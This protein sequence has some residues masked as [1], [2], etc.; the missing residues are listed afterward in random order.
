MRLVL[1]P[2]AQRRLDEQEE[3]LRARDTDF[4]QGEDSDWYFYICQKG[5]FSTISECIP[6]LLQ[7]SRVWST[8]HRRLMLPNEH[9]RVMGVPLDPTVLSLTDNQRRNMAGNAMRKG[10]L[11]TVLLYTLAAIERLPSPSA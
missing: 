9:C 5:K 2:G 7:N 10:A 11:G 6:A 1:C 3:R 8:R 4:D